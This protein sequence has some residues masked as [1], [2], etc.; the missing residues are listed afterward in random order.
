[1]EKTPKYDLSQWN[2]SDRILMEDFNRDNANL[3][4]ALAALAA[5]QAAETARVNT[6]LAKK[7]E[8][9]ALNSAKSALEAEDARLNSVKL[10]FVTLL[11]KTYTASDTTQLNI[12]ING[13]AI[14]QC[15]AACIDVY[16]DNVTGS[17]ITLGFG[18]NGG[19]YGGEYIA[20]YS[21]TRVTDA[22]LPLS[23][24]ERALLLMFPMKRG[25]AVITT[26]SGSRNT[27]HGRWNNSYNDLAFLRIKCASAFSADFRVKISGIR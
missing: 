9:S 8:A 25:D 1:M 13:V 11:D 15:V 4:A 23:T 20:P 16:P 6:E 18:N 10:E 27:Y 21:A 22:L 12:P 3:E 26:F 24:R 19:A 14:G 2:R 17:N 7:A 5:G